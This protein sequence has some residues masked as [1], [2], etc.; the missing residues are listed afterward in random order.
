M[1]K[2]CLLARNRKILDIYF[3]KFPSVF[4]LPAFML[5]ASHE[6]SWCSLSCFLPAADLRMMRVW[7]LGIWLAHSLCHQ[8][9]GPL[10]GGGWK[11]ATFTIEPCP[12]RFLHLR[13]VNFLAMHVNKSLPSENTLEL[14]S[15]FSRLE[16]LL[17]RKN[18]F[19]TTLQKH[20]LACGSFA[21]T[22]TWGW[23]IC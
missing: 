15:V 3:W 23:F 10:I 13:V 22:K 20:S 6:F 9:H 21:S 16:S 4:F 17:P 2:I 7:G 18:V 5:T 11:R 8:H 19:K 1:M 14:K 12:R